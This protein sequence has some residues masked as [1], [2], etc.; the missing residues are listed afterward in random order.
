MKPILGI[1]TCGV[2]HQR[3]FTPNTYINAGVH[4]GFTPVILPI[5]QSLSSLMS[6]LNMCDAFLF[7]G[8]EDITPLLYGQELLDNTGT[9]D[10]I[11]DTFHIR[12]M[13]MVLAS[14][15]PVVGI[16]RG[17]QVMNVALGGTLH[18]DLDSF[19]PGK[20]MAH[21]QNSARRSDVSHEVYFTPG[22]HLYQRYGKSAQVNSYHHQGL[23]ELGTN[24]QVTGVAKDGVIES[25]EIKKH[26][27]AVG[28]QWHPECLLDVNILI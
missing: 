3:H 7:C 9:T 1:L 25:I 27:Y 14:Q 6:Y 23:D 16:C 17:M 8:G 21:M 10:M 13:R 15:K 12:F 2:E 22:S 5:T 20:N 19:Y 4:C 28:V 24:V 18:Q 11:L 26:P